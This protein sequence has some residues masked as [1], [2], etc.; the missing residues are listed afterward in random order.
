MK[1]I[2]F[3][4]ATLATT[5]FAGSGYDNPSKEFMLLLHSGNATID[6]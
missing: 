3:A 6:G 1:S 2:L 4:I 5:A